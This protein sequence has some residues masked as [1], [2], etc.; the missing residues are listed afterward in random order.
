MKWKFGL[1]LILSLLAGAAGFATGAPAPE[2]KSGIAVG[3][4]APDFTLRDQ[5]GQEQSLTKLLAEG[6]IA[7]VFFRSASW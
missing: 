2:G 7:L 3:E 6:P 1:C 5:D 4:K